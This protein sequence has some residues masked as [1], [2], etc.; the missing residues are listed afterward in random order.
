V[1]S[2]F[3]DQTELMEQNT[4]VFNSRCFRFEFRMSWQWR[5]GC[6]DWNIL[7]IS[8]VSPVCHL[9]PSPYTSTF[10]I[11]LFLIASRFFESVAVYFEP[12]R[13]VY[14]DVSSDVMSLACKE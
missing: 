14:N 1:F 5:P 10:C 8:S 12:I 9:L 2:Y 13:N 7:C 3:I 11:Q 4:Q 6:R